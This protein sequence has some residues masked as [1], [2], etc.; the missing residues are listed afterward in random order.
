MKSLFPYLV[1]F[2]KDSTMLLKE[3]LDNCMISS[4][5]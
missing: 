5:N 4:L 1:K 3:Y 2:S